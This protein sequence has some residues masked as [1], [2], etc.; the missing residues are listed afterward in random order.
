MR[1]LIDQESNNVSLIDCLEQ[2]NIQINKNEESLKDKVFPVAFDFVSLFLDENDTKE[3]KM[4]FI[5]EVIDP[6][7][8]KISEFPGEIIM[9]KGIK[10]Y[11]NRLKIQGLK[12]TDSGKYLFKLKVKDFSGEK[13][14]ELAEIPLE[15]NISYK[16]M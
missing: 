13:Y 8:K 5:L 1:S 10:R 7:N 15:V 16:L 11:R 3:R 2:L 14:K 6:S 12:I 4:E 9:K